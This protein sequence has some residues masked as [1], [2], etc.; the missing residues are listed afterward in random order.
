M[1]PH[2]KRLISEVQ[3]R[4]R[5]ADFA[6]LVGMIQMMRRWGLDP[7]PDNL[8][9]R[10]TALSAT[11]PEIPDEEVI[12]W[13]YQATLPRRV[14]FLAY[15][16]LSEESLVAIPMDVECVNFTDARLTDAGIAQLLRLTD[17][18]RLILSGTQV[19]DAGLDHLATLP[20][21]RYL[22][23]DRTAVSEEG[24]TRLKLRLP[25]LD[26]KR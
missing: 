8:M 22:A 19:T 2:V 20:N 18:S 5:Y 21:L 1:A 10:M 6:I 24:V 4:N 7:D 12:G 17:L 13:R 16:S 11:G 3:S 26:V 15:T 25:N 23:V 9:L 14:L